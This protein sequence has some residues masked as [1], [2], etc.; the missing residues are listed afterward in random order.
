M[1]LIFLGTSSFAVPILER[2]IAAKYEV[3]AVITAPGATPVKKIALKCRLTLLQPE[4]ISRIKDK[5]AGLKPDLL[6]LAAYGQFIPAS[7]LTLPPFRCLNLHPSLLPEYRGPSPIQTALL[8]GKKQTGVSIIVMDQEIDHGPIVGQKPLA[9]GPQ[10]DYPALERRL[11]RLA[12]DLLITILPKY[13]AGEIKP[14]QQ[15]HRRATHTK[16]LTRQDGYVDLKMPASEIE[17]KVRALSPWP[18]VWTILRGKRLKVLKANASLDGLL[19]L[20]LVQPAG[21]RPMTWE[22][23]LRGQR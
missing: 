14:Q 19:D 1:K 4:K 8:D 5:I 21:K 10:D 16:A 17:K 12:A 6:V 11:A 13:I 23:F 2:L 3:A 15:N 22:E 18:G 7:V 9:I 20:K